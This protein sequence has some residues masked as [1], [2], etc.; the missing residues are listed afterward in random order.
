MK[1]QWVATAY[2]FEEKSVML[3]YMLFSSQHESALLAVS[4]FVCLSLSSSRCAK[5][6]AS[7][8]VQIFPATTGETAKIKTRFY[9]TEHSCSNL[10]GNKSMSV[11]YMFYFGCAGVLYVC[12]SKPRIYHKT[13]SEGFGFGLCWLLPWIIYVQYIEKFVYHQQI[14]K[15]WLHMCQ[16][17]LNYVIGCYGVLRGL[18]F[19]QWCCW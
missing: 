12:N 7:A 16:L 14:Y 9:L 2:M 6:A 10:P 3:G 8:H 19:L 11:Y 13:Q 15:L 17:L 18:V 4:L 5:W 1:P